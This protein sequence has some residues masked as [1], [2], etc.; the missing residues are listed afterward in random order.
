M[1]QDYLDN[2]STYEKAYLSVQAV[3]TVSF[4]HTEN[5]MEYEKSEKDSCLR[6]A[7][8]TILKF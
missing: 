2:Y 6:G 1:L 7:V 8:P 4:D 3:Y 5:S